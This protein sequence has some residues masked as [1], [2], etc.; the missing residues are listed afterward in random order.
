M[1]STL[2]SLAMCHALGTSYGARAFELPADLPSR[3]EG[4]WVIDQTGTISDDKTTIEIQK[5]W[6]A[7]LDA[8]ADRALHELEV[9]EQQSN[10]ARLNETCEEPQP[11]ISE[12]ALSWSMHCSGLSPAGENTGTSNVRHTTTFVT[13]EET[14]AESTIVNRDKLIRSHGQFLT[15]MK[16]VGSCEGGSSPRLRLEIAGFA[17]SAWPRF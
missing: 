10:I 9:R 5:I 15:Y 3:S 4:L 1:R 12:N 6:N 16:R 11:S 14:R 13:G 7:C 17:L 2:I 8:R